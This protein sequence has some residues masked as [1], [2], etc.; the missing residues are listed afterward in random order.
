[1]TRDWTL[2]NTVWSNGFNLLSAN[3]GPNNHLPQSYH[4]KIISYIAHTY[5]YLDLRIYRK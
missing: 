2:V 4:T 5:F 3:G 1:M